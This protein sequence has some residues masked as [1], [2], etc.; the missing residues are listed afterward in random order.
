MAGTIVV[1]ATV[2]AAT[3]KL[4]LRDITLCLRVRHAMVTLETGLGTAHSMISS[5]LRDGI[6]FHQRDDI[7]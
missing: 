1:A 5:L 2:V 6:L 3:V 4:L 7:M